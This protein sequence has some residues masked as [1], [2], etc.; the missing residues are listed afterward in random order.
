MGIEG[1]DGDERK[2]LRNVSEKLRKL[3]SQ[4]NLKS[5]GRVTRLLAQLEIELDKQIK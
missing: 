4:K 5:A 2:M 3:A 1:L